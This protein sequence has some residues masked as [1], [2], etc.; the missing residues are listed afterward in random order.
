MRRGSTKESTLYH[1][2]KIP[3]PDGYVDRWICW[4]IKDKAL[5]VH[6]RYFGRVFMSCGCEEEHV[7]K[8]P[9]CLL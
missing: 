5:S 6:P 1:Y 7:P 9:M 8:Q 4:T 2:P 3:N